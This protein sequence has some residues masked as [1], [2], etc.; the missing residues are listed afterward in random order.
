VN[1]VL[2]GYRASGKTVTGR[3][4]AARLSRPFV[5]TDV[6]VIREAGAP[7]SE[8]VQKD[9]WERFRDLESRVIRRVASSDGQVVSTGGGA[10]LREENVR[11]LRAGGWIVWLKA[12]EE[13]LRLRMEAD[14]ENT[15]RR[16]ALE[17]ESPVEEIAG[18]LRGRTPFYRKAGHFHL[19]T[20][21][22]S[23][24]ETA[25]RILASMPE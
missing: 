7:V 20:D 1:L 25:N 14:V 11:R 22:L 13:I 21:G 9:G 6:L 24:S 3:E 4:L 16:P 2:I 17:G 18:V 19:D 12:C 5:D 10:V 23:P 8:I 15:E